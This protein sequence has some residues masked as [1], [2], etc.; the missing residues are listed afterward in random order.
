MYTRNSFDLPYLPLSKFDPDSE[1]FTYLKSPIWEESFSSPNITS[2]KSLYVLF[3][4]DEEF[5]IIEARFDSFVI[6]SI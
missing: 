2:S 1:L 4:S 6:D 3:E 5:K